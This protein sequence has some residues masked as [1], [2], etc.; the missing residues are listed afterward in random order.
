MS[1]I[2]IRILVVDDDPFT[3]ELTGMTLEAAGYEAVVAEG[4]LDAMEK[5]AENPSFA[6]VVSDMNM[7]FMSGAELFEELGK[8][9]IHLP[10]LLLTGQDAQ[11]LVAAHP[12]MDA[13][14]KKDEGFQEALQEHLKTL[15]AR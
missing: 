13:V 15:L 14:L 10:F 4:G 1:D 6:A 11:E 3:A 7:P 5:V 12:G 8:L 9:G 2:S